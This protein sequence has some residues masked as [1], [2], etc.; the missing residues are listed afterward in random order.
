MIKYL[1]GFIL[2]TST[3][4]LAAQTSRFPG[5]TLTGGTAS[6]ALYL[7]ANKAIT[8]SSTVSDTEL[9]YL[10]GVTASLC[11]AT[12]TCTLTNK[13][14][15]RTV[16]SVSSATTLA[17]TV[18]F[19]VIT[20]ATKQVDLFTAV[21][22]GGRVVEIMHNGSNFSQVYTIEGN[23]SETIGSVDTYFDMHTKGEILKVVS[24][25]SNWLVLNHRAQT[26]WIN[27]GAVTIGA[28]TTPPTK[29]S[30]IAVD[31]LLYRRDGA[32]LIGRVEYRQTNTTDTAAGS[33]DYLYTITPTGMLI[34]TS[35]MVT[36]YTTAEGTGPWLTNNSVGSVNVNTNSVSTSGVVI[37]YDTTRV[38]LCS[39]YQSAEGC[40]SNGFGPITQSNHG[41]VFNFRVPISNWVH[42]P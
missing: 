20:G 32:D 6:R 11:G 19:V 16:T 10:D 23:S 12:Q 37:V 5:V 8:S 28:T 14:V 30:G 24:D 17:S 7:D 29:A 9:G 13:T 3:F 35:S 36:A 26:P 25:G 27:A 1:I 21:G 41:F 18:D 2:F 31:R 33:G 15:T 40:L 38:K 42:N 34:D 4:L 39:V 22:N